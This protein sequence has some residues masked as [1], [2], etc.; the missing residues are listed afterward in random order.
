M[1]PSHL[2]ATLSLAADTEIDLAL[3]HGAPGQ[4]APTG[5]IGFVAAI[6]LGAVP[7]IA[8]AW[9]SILRPHGLSLR[10]TGVFCHQTP[11]A[12]FTDAS[13]MS[14]LC[15][16]SD[17]LVVAEDLTAGGTARRW[18]TLI[19]AK[20]AN[21]GGG[22]TLSTGGDLVQLDLMTRWPPFNLPS[23]YAPG[24]R[25]F[26]NCPY[27]GTPIECGRYGLIEPRPNLDW[28]Q[29]APARSMP[30]GGNTLGSFLAHMIETGQSGY[31]REATGTGDDWSRTVDELMR[32]TGAQAFSHAAGFSGQ[33]Q[34]GHSAIAFISN[35][36]PPY[37][38]LS[39]YWFGHG[40]DGP[41]PTGGRPDGPE[42]FE[43]GPEG[44]GISLLRIGVTRIADGEG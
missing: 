32:V 4:N 15:E 20:I 6:V 1:I 18:A 41:L 35:P 7:G 38:P 13:G 21:S 39:D 40:A 37:W 25:D 26:S 11:R 24:A 22:T 31:G 5:E 8:S 30:S 14:R 42:Y 28:R 29:R 23:G 27:P 2:T 17:L 16:L 10:M 19:Q 9:R 3:R 43:D 36:Y 34:R 12:S 44:E 33:R